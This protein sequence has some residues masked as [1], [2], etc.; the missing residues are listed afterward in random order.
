MR[1]NN[2]DL[3]AAIRP[4]SSKAELRHW[5]NVVA[6]VPVAKQA[7]AFRRALSQADN[8][9]PG[10]AVP[11]YFAYQVQRAQIAIDGEP[12][13]KLVAQVRADRLPKMT[14]DWASQVREVVDRRYA[15]ALRGG[16]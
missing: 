15:A 4:G 8:F 12:K 10:E 11:K 13:W 14:E 2:V 16:G 5:V 1:G 7:E 3:G 6:K 9:Q